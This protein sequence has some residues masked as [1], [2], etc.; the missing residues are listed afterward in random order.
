MLAVSRSNKT[1]EPTLTNSGVLIYPREDRYPR[2]AQPYGGG[3]A[4]VWRVETPVRTPTCNCRFTIA[5]SEQRAL[6]PLFT[7]PLLLPSKD[8]LN[9]R[10]DS[11]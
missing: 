9:D 11:V 10:L 3:R 5:A 2:I 8:S 4:V 6:F 1:V 7:I